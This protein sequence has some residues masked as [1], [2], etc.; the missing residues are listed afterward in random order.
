MSKMRYLRF[1]FICLLLAGCGT[2]TS[3]RYDTPVPSTTS[4]AFKDERPPESRQSRYGKSSN[5]KLV[6][7][8]DDNLVP[9]GPELLKAALE[10]R[11]HQELKGK[12]VSV[13]EFTVFVYDS[14]MPPE[15]DRQKTAA[16]TPGGYAAAP[17]AGL[18]LGGFERARS[19]KVV[20]VLIRGNV[21]RAEFSTTSSDTYRG[22]VSERDVQAT[23]SKAL[24]KAAAVVQQTVEKR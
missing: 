24:E 5:A 21:D 20:R 10:S 12:T 4:F 13:K 9:S 19:D 8:G 2:V 17:F 16:S 22:R 6:Y 14:A 7:F 3:V 1:V 18:F 23:L 15:N 11:L